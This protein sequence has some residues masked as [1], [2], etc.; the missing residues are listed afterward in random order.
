MS[1]LQEP[2]KAQTAYFIFFNEKR[3]EF[4]KQLGGKAACGPLAKLASE[5]W[6]VMSSI[7]REPF[8]KK[9]ADGKAQYEKD[10][11]A[12]K[13]AGGEV[14]QKRKEKRDKKRE[15][16]A[17]AEK[18]EANAGKPKKLAGAWG[19]Y[20]TQHG[21]EIIKNMPA[22]SP[23]TMITKIASEQWNAL[24]EPQKAPYV[25][26]YE[27]KKAAYEV[28]MKAWKEARSA[29]DAN[30]EGGRRRRRGSQRPGGR[31]RDAR[32][33][34]KEGENRARQPEGAFIR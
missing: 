21:A 28:E 26:Q 30:G 14:G 5:R 15:R 10:L 23:C 2:K 31:G 20:L 4:A 9:A 25:E 32:S 17:R 19:C 13:E 12:F 8:E 22:G 34:T 3:A 6:A 33:Q 29:P 18:K 11:L 27:Q 1:G 24:S 7:E 16:E